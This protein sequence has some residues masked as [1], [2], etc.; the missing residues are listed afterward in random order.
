[1]DGFPYVDLAYFILQVALEM[2]SWP[3]VK[4]AIYATQ[5]LER[6]SRLGLSEREARALVRLSMFEADMNA[7]EEGY[8]DDHPV[9]AWRRRISRGLW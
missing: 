5:W 9:R 2:Y 6:Q 7:K 4:S 1:M 8:P 3:A